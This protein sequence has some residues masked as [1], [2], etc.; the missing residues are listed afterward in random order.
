MR[1]SRT[2]RLTTFLS[3]M[4]LLGSLLVAS[5][6]GA[7]GPFVQDIGK[8]DL[9]LS[10]ASGDLFEYTSPAGDTIVG[11]QTLSESKC[12]ISGPETLVDLEASAL[13]ANPSPSPGIKD[14]V[15]GVKA[16]GEGNGEPCARINDANDQ[17]LTMTLTGNELGDKFIH[18]A[19]FGVKLKFGAT[20]RV[21]LF[22]G[23]VEVVHAE[24]EC[25]EGSDCGP[26]S[27]ADRKLLELPPDDGDGTEYIGDTLVFKVTSPASGAFGILDDPVAG[28]DSYITIAEE[29]DGT[30]NCGDQTDIGG[31]DELN[32]IFWRIS[33]LAEETDPCDLKPF[34]ASVSEQGDVITFA[35][36]AAGS[37]QNFAA[38]IGKITSLPYASGPEQPTKKLNYDPL[39][40]SGARI[41]EW[42]DVG[43]AATLPKPWDDTLANTPAEGP[44][45]AIL[46]FVADSE[47]AGEE[48]PEVPSGETWC[49]VHSE[50]VPVSGGML[51]TVFDV[52]GEGDPNFF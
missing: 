51:V 4:A 15:I 31:E 41:M 45:A 21:T 16:K 1:N 23:N 52:T 43:N 30:L 14:H 27:G 20:A 33:N 49:L 7:D 6:A 19:Q 26:D 47:M 28:F 29:F 44:L 5:S 39:D 25:T 38:Y 8:L 40:G 48:F 24:A 35:P 36:A 2:K 46:G 34:N 17:M 32:G 42:C 22:N 10:D 13:A 50:T 9:I 37:G 18:G 11:T 3:L 12:K